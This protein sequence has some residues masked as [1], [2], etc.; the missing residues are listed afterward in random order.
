MHRHAVSDCEL[1]MPPIL[2]RQHVV[3]TLI[4]FVGA[5][6]I[7]PTESFVEDRRTVRGFDFH[8]ALK[9]PQPFPVRNPGGQ[10][11]PTVH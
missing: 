4:S 2:H 7:N 9:H 10:I 5:G 8:L 3:F 1:N 11:E 6:Q